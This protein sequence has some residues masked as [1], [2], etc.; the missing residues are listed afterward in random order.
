MMIL[1]L[2]A[3]S[4]PTK[5]FESLFSGLISLIC[6]LR[7]YSRP[8]YIFIKDIQVFFIEAGLVGSK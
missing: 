5:E 7:V 1:Q 3:S 6:L 2:T 4:K 8:P